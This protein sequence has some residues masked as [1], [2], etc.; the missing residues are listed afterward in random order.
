M[1]VVFEVGANEVI[2]STVVAATLWFW[3]SEELAGNAHF[4]ANSAGIRTGTIN[5]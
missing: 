4:V 5:E 2:L 3:L 1:F